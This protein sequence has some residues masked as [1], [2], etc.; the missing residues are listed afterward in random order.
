[1]VGGL[2]SFPCTSPPFIFPDTPVTYARG[3]ERVGELTSFMEDDGELPRSLADYPTMSKDPSKIGLYPPTLPIEVALQE[4]SLADIKA[5]YQFT[6]EEWAALPHNP[7]FISDLKAAKEMLK[8]EGM[9]F[10]VKARLQADE[11]LKRSWVL[12]HSSTDVVPPSVQADLIKATM[13]WAGYD[14]KETAVG[15]VNNGF[16]IQINLR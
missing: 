11:L 6:D 5:E 15:A 1:M 4:T 7:N 2:V 13:R 10:K 12:I 9:S 8:K 16:N 3:D 14:N